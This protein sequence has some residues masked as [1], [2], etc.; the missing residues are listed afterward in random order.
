MSEPQAILQFLFV[1]ALLAFAGLPV[2]RFL[3]SDLPDQGWAFSRILGHVFVGWV[4]WMLCSF[5]LCV[6][7]PLLITVVL[8]IV[9]VL[10]WIFVS[11][12]VPSKMT[13]GTIRLILIEE[14]MLVA[15]FGIWIYL[16]GYAPNLDNVEKFMD[17]GF[18][19]SI[20]KSEFFPPL[21][22]FLARE[23]INYY[24]FGH[25][26][27]AAFLMLA[28]VPLSIGYSLQ[29][30]YLMGLTLMEVFAVAF[31]LVAAMDRDTEA[32]GLGKESGR[33]R[34]RVLTALL[35]TAFIGVMGNAATFVDLVLKQQEK[36]WY[37]S[38]TRYIAKTIHEFPMYNFVV[39]DLHG[40]VFDL[41]VSFLMIALLFVVFKHITAKSNEANASS[42]RPMLKVVWS[43]RFFWLF[44]SF[45]FFV[46]AAYAINAW[47][48]PIYLFLAGLTI[49][50]GL[51]LAASGV[52]RGWTSYI[53]WNVVGIA[54]L[55]AGALVALSIGL[56]YP[57]WWDYTRIYAQFSWVGVEWR[58]PVFQ[59]AAAWGNHFI[60]GGLFFLFFILPRRSRAS[61]HRP[62]NACGEFLKILFFGSLFLILACENAHIDDIYL[63][64]PRANTV[65]K[66]Y[67][68]AWLWLGLVVA[69]GYRS[70]FIFM[71]VR[72]RC[73]LAVASLILVANLFV[74]FLFTGMA[75]KQGFGGFRRSHWTLDGLDY[76][77][78]AR[79]SDYAAIHWLNDNIKGQPT[80]VEAVGESFSEF[81]RI[82][83]FT[84]FPTVLGWP[85]HEMLWRGFYD[86]PIRPVTTLFIKTGKPDTIR[87]RRSEIGTLYETADVAVAKELLEKYEVS[88]VYVGGLERKQ[89]KKLNEEKFRQIAKQVVY[90]RQGVTIYEIGR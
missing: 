39:N 62:L 66:F 41:P 71:R 69:F 51:A 14:A 70:F 36:Y 54:L 83:V 76:L 31:A 17:Y 26:L 19:A 48:Y 90:D 23:T 73:F 60:G 8:V 24:Y 46:G 15:V 21:D 7:S 4:V 30:A 53:R 1:G 55:L 42:I 22:H 32:Q 3:F 13:A 65:Y 52:S 44:V 59:F 61:G 10:T 75:I 57:Y 82:S 84:G 86:G 27:A 16:R 88:Y 67:Y 29:A 49:W 56:F 47:D 18:M 58:S 11:P 9:A 81:G 43:G 68:Q 35:A 12:R 34:L 20:S 5:R 78:K 64:T 25:Y 63:K 85:G 37:P 2:V 74:G 89:Y 33:R 6:F 50:I 45:A 80:I 72:G 28:R 40:Q 79:N 77:K 87:I 38:A